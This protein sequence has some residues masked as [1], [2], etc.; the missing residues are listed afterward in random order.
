MAGLGAKNDKN[1]KKTEGWVM[2]FSRIKT[3]GAFFAK[4]K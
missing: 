3:K 4:R 2:G 1:C